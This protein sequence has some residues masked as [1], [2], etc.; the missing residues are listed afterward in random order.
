MYSQYNTPN[1]IIGNDREEPASA[2]PCVEVEIPVIPFDRFPDPK[3]CA[4]PDFTEGQLKRI[5]AAERDWDSGEIRAP[6]M[7]LATVR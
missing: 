1:V 2:M 6:R 5:A 4:A 7:M 3:E